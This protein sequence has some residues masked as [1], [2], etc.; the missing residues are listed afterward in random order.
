MAH[1]R[2]IMIP[3]ACSKQRCER[4]ALKNPSAVLR[5]W[6][7]NSVAQSRARAWRQV[8]LR[9]VLSPLI[10]DLGGPMVP[11][12][13]RASRDKGPARWHQLA[14]R[15]PASG[16]SWIIVD[17]QADFLVRKSP[18]NYEHACRP[19]RRV[20]LIKGQPFWC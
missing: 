1:E 20:T 4:K 12:E 17:F 9:A 16:I 6:T 7:P 8:R 3:P 10:P 2:V 19:R 14:W 11:A 18:A 13:S 15:P 5:F